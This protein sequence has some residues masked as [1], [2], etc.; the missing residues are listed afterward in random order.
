M[1]WHGT[2]LGSWEHMNI[3]HDIHFYCIMKR[4]T[5]ICRVNGKRR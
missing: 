4:D 5:G 1:R 3:E 2:E